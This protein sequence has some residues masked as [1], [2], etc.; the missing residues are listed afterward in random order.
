MRVTCLGTMAYCWIG[1]LAEG[2]FYPRVPLEKSERFLKR[3]QVLSSQKYL[4][5]ILEMNE[6][7][8]CHFGR[9]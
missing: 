2:R 1:F 4:Y 7:I 5:Y 8:D 6:Y 9:K 3:P